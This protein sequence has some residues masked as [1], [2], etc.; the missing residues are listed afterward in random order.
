MNSRNAWGRNTLNPGTIDGV[1]YALINAS[2]L[3]QVGRKGA[4]E[5]AVPEDLLE[6]LFNRSAL[7]AGKCLQATRC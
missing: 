5:T 2:S 6:R 4:S 1:S 3:I 7:N